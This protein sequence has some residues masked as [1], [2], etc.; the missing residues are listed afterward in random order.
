MA[1]HQLTGCGEAK[2]NDNVMQ[3]MD[4]EDKDN[5][6][7]TPQVLINFFSSLEKILTFPSNKLNS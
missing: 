4:P 6:V 1:A 7:S 3:S 5:P 2:V